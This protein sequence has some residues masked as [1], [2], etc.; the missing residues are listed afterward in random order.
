MLLAGEMLIMLIMLNPP[1]DFPKSPQFDL[2]LLTLLTFPLPEAFFR[3]YGFNIID[4]IPLWGAKNASGRGMLIMLIMLNPLPDF[5]KSPQFDSNIINIINISPA[6]SLFFVNMDLT[7][8]TLLTFPL[9]EAKNAAGRG[10]VNNVNNVK[11]T[12]GFSQES[13][14]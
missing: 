10:N 11:S 14:I 9:W 6:R 1:P 8:L 2:T 4:V 7:L 5:P 3:E 12:S 13:R